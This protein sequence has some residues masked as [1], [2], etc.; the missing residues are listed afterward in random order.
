MIP[1]KV[2][3]TQKG[4]SAG[5]DSILKVHDGLELDDRELVSCWLVL[6]VLRDEIRQNPRRFGDDWF[7]AF[8]AAE[9]YLS[10][11]G[12]GVLGVMG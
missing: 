6:S 4:V 10:A 3:L 8:L 12:M 9:K 1:D 2:Y 7:K 5:L 11:Q